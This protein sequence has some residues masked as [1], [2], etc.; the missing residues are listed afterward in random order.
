M[1]CLRG[2]AVELGY[3]RREASASDGDME[4]NGWLPTG[5]A[6]GDIGLYACISGSSVNAPSNTH[7]LAALSFASH[8]SRRLI[9]CS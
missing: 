2:G 9:S 7:L 3:G 5:G 6:S 8:L 4:V 1:I